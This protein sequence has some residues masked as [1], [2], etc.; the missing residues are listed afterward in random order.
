MKEFKLKDTWIVKWRQNEIDGEFSFDVNDVLN[1]CLCCSNLVSHASRCINREHKSSIALFQHN[2]I[3]LL[4]TNVLFDGFQIAVCS[5]VEIVNGKTLFDL[6]LQYTE[7]KLLDEDYGK[8][9]SS[10]RK[11]HKLKNMTCFEIN[12]HEVRNKMY[13]RGD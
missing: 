8:K 13:F 5:L 6:F 4:S 9:I 3:E 7:Y 12:F 11:F 2:F 10:G 1:N